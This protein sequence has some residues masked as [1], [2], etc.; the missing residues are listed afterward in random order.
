MVDSRIM[1]QCGLDPDK[2]ARMKQRI[3][4]LELEVQ[5]DIENTPMKE[6]L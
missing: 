5:K 4:E 6:M 1:T 3:A 2:I